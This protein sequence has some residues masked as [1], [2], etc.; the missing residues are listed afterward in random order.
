V[1]AL[2][3][4]TPVFVDVEAATCNMD[5]TSLPAVISPRTKAV[6]PVSLYGQPGNMDEINAVAAT[7]GFAVIEDAA[8]SFGA[9]YHGR[10]SCGLSLI[11]CTSFFPS[12][13]LGCYGDGGAIF[14]ADHELAQ[15]MREIRVH[16]QSARYRHTRIGIGGRMDTIQCAIVLAKLEAFES[17]LAARTRIG[18]RYSA[19]F[20]G[21]SD[22]VRLIELQ[23]GTTS[24]YAQYT[25]LVENRDEVQQALASEGIP[26]AVHYPL[27]IHRQPAYERWAESAHCPVSEWLSQHV[28]SLPMHPYLD[29]ATQILITAAVGRHAI[30]S[31]LKCPLNA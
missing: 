23:D 10:N 11:G 15:A 13:P 5:V 17:E 6:L 3:G 31:D 9:T 16:G 28:L 8:Q 4:A 14:T 1:I 2:L 7:H 30:E 18:S 24:A 27:P 29:E 25:I 20:E 22:R 21:Y 19:L 12:K 26:T